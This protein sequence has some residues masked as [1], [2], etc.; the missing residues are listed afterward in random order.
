M[1]LLLLLFIYH[2]HC[3]F[4]LF[5][6]LFNLLGCG[7][8]SLSVNLQGVLDVLVRVKNGGNE[9][10]GSCTLS[11][12]RQSVGEDH[13]FLKVLGTLLL[14]FMRCKMTEILLS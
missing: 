8:C 14:V 1:F 13:T 4:K 5:I 9:D 3:L 7:L 2:C 6:H 10:D 11:A 12:F